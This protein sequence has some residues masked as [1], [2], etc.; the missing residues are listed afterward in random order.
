MK[1]DFALVT[2]CLRGNGQEGLSAI[3]NKADV[4]S[5]RGSTDTDTGDNNDNRDNNTLHPWDDTQ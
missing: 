4:D 1:N 3:L 5:N 2:D